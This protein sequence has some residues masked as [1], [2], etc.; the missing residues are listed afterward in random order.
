MIGSIFREKLSFDGKQHRTKRLNEVVSIIRMISSELQAKKKPFS[1][2]KNG[3]L[4]C[5]PS[6]A[7]TSDQK[8]MS[9]LL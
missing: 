5:G 3:F 2:S 1:L 7:R 8:I 6:W 4:F 9:L